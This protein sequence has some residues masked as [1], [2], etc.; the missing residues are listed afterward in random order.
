MY[1]G[2]WQRDRNCD[3]LAQDWTRLRFT[4]TGASSENWTVSACMCVS[5]IFQAELIC[6]DDV[7]AEALC[8]TSNEK[9]CTYEL[10]FLRITF[11][12]STSS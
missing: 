11:K 2:Q 4:S 3:A 5:T 12:P 8:P 10:P 7:D 1:T 6:F 9:E